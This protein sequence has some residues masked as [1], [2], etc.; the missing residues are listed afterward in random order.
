MEF[1]LSL[2]HDLAR[3][4]Y[5]G[6]EE[7]IDIK[8]LLYHRIEKFETLEV[9]IQDLKNQKI[10]IKSEYEKIAQKLTR[11]RKEKANYRKNATARNDGSML[12]YS[13]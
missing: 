12:C 7:L 6:F 8:K 9:R 11:N 2:L 10:R 3:K 1:R 4:H 5:V 13:L